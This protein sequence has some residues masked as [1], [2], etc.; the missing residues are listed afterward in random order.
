MADFFGSALSGSGTVSQ[1][2]SSFAHA[3]QRMTLSR[4][5]SAIHQTTAN[6]V[7]GYFKSSDRILDV[8]MYSDGAGSAGALNLGVDTVEFSNGTAE[9]TVL[10][11]DLFA[12]AAATAT[13]ILYGSATATRFTEA[14]ILNEYDRGKAF[15]ELAAIGAGTDTVDPGLTY[16]IV[17]DVS[18]LITAATEL[19]FVVDYVAGD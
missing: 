9:R 8:R 18:T 16:A 6:L 10:D 12:S 11:V 19:A 3:R 4:F 7:I 1:S 15:W 2:T 17:A 14:G 13:A 5:A